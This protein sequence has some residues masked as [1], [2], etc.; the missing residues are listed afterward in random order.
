MLNAFTAFLVFVAI[1]ITSALLWCMLSTCL[2]PQILEPLRNLWD[3][4]VLSARSSRGPSGRR[5][6]D[7]G[8]DLNDPEY[9]LWEMERRSRAI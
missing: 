7:L 4:A 5:R 8:Y 3:A 6:R 2:G 1:L 9:E